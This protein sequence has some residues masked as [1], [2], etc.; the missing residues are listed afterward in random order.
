MV[1]SYGL[2][3]KNARETSLSSWLQ[4]IGDLDDAPLLEQRLADALRHSVVQVASWSPPE[5]RPAILW[6]HLLW[7]LP[8]WQRHWQKEILPAAVL[9]SPTPEMARLEERWRAGTPLLTAWLDQW[10]LLWPVRRGQWADA[11]GALSDMLQNHARAFPTL[12]DADAARQARQQL[13]Q[14]LRTLFRRH[15]GQPAAIFIHLALMAM[16]FERLRGGLL[17]RALFPDHAGESV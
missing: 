7:Q 8:L 15:I 4:A 9:L 13:Q 11:L 2:F 5:W 12:P 16:D 14:R 3:L 6:S 1:V 10:I 17:L